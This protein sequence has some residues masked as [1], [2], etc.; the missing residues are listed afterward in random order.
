MMARTSALLRPFLLLGSVVALFEACGDPGTSTAPEVPA[1]GGSGSGGGGGQRFPQDA[2]TTIPDPNQGGASAD[3]YR[4]GVGDCIPDS[5]ASCSGSAMAD[6]G[7]V[8]EPV[9]ACRLIRGV[10]QVGGQGGANSVLGSECRSAGTGKLDTP[11]L[12]TDDC[13]AGLACVG[14]GLV[15]RCRPYCCRDDACDGMGR[16]F[17]SLAPEREVDAES[18]GEPSLVPVCVAADDCDLGEPYPCPAGRDCQCADGKACLVVRSGE[19]GTATA[20]LGMTACVEPGQGEAGDECPCAFGHVC[21]KGTAKCLA[22]C[23]TVAPDAPC[24]AH[25][26]ASSELPLGWGVC[27]D[28]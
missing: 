18:E 10:E 19:D 8:Q 28:S 20:G 26:Q 21:S 25:C 14:G 4:C 7:E 16:T 15:G 9:L 17:C 27:I 6:G 13:G 3:D 2:T 1:F 5:P 23:S 12:S 24:S 11:C 22:L